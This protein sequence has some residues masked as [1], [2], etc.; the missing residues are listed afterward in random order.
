MEREKMAGNVKL[1]H[2]AYAAR[3]VDKWKRWGEM[4][5]IEF[6]KATDTDI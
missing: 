6:I 4:A 5:K 1:G 3:E 2:R